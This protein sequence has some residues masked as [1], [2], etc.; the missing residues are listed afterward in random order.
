ML[1]RV[2]KHTIIKLSRGKIHFITVTDLSENIQVWAGIKTQVI[3][4]EFRIQSNNNDEI[5]LKVDLRNALRAL[6][7]AT[8]AALTIVK[9]TKKQGIPYLTIEMKKP[10]GQVQQNNQQVSTISIVQDIPVIV[11]TLDEI[12]EL[13]EPQLPEPPV[14]IMMPHLKDL[15]SVIERLKSIG[16]YITISAT[17]ANSM[18][19]RLDTPLIQCNTLYKNLEHPRISG[20]ESLQKDPETRA[21]AKL[22]I[23][24]FSK[25]LF[26]HLLNPNEVICSI[27]EDK[28][29]I[30]SVLLQVCMYELKF[31][32]MSRI[33]I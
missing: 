8:T 24:K 17:M 33:F 20:R 26:A 6:K 29:V 5:Y 3:M 16:D 9:L 1:E 2:H 32:M 18:T 23:K 27:L 7:S 10:S 13:S 25:F 30:M 28:C 11:L 19:L 31:T 21:T 12:S 4:S 14:Q 22:D 15:K